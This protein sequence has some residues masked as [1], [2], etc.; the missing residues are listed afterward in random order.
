MAYICTREGNCAE[1]EHFR[2]DEEEGRY[3]CFAV[4]DEKVAQ[5]SRNAH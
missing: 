5:A 4:Q 3:A 2:F 1:C